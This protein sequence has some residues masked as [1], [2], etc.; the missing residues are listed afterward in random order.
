M[1]HSRL[2][3]LSAFVLV[4]TISGARANTIVNGSFEDPVIIYPFYENFGPG[5]SG[6]CAPGPGVLPGWTITT[7]NV[8]IVS[9]LPGGWPAP[10]KDGNQY[11]DLV[12]YGS[13]GGISQT[14][15]TTPGQKYNLSFAY[16]N[17]PGSTSFASANV[18]VT[19]VSSVVL[20]AL[21]SANFS[22]TNDIG[23]HI[24]TASFVANSLNTTLS[25]DEVVGGNNGGVLL[26]AINVSAT[27]LPSTWTMLIAGFVGFGFFAYR[28]S[29]NR[30]AAVGAA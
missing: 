12:G 3:A 27:P 20:P 18:N 21:F 8:D 15:A 17:N 24:F 29:K 5:C 4:T 26:D 14:F 7:N 10:A 16:G 11:L 6:N 13:T 19:P 28:G 2:I 1:T 25:F 23:W 9:A 30:S 22:T